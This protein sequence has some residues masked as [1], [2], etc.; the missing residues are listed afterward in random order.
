MEAHGGKSA[1]KLGRHSTRS[2]AEK[3]M[4]QTN[5]ATHGA[6][7]TKMQASEAN[8]RR[9]TSPHQFGGHSD[10]KII[11]RPGSTEAKRR[12]RG[13]YG[14]QRNWRRAGTVST[15]GLRTGGTWPPG[16]AH[17]RSCRMLTAVLPGVR[18]TAAAVTAGGAHQRS[19]P[20][21]A[22]AAAESETLPRLQT[23]IGRAH[24]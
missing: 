9:N 20:P 18:R 3:Q 14:L 4:Q 7:G 6:H 11:L 2:K 10:L 24:V 17:Q 21:K 15:D 22:A 12:G 5:V 13:A 16:E 8:G 1:T 23:K 19:R